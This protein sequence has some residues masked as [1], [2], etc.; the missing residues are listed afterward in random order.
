MKAMKYHP[1]KNRED[2]EAEEK[3]K[4]ISEAYQILSDP[5]KRSHYNTYGKSAPSDSVFVDPEEFFKQQF[6]G[7]K[8]VDI[9]GEISIAKDFKEAMNM[10]SKGE[11]GDGGASSGGAGKEAGSGKE[12]AS[13]K[14]GLGSGMSMEERIEIRNQRINKLSQS[15]VEKL[16]LFSDAFP[17][18][19]QIASSSPPIGASLDQMAQEALDSFRTVAVMETDTLKHENY[20][21]ELLHAI[22][23]TYTLKAYQHL[24]KYDVEEGPVLRRAWGLGSRFAGIMKEKAHIINETVGTFRTA[25]DLQTSFAKLQEMEKKKEEKKKKKDDGSSSDTG[26]KD[27]T[28]SDTDEDHLTAEE[29]ELRQKLEFEAASKG[30]EALWRGSKLEVEAVLR[31]VCDKVLS[32]EA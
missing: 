18:P 32:D 6:G 27:P 21:V 8:F 23:Y 3:F 20:G 30:L 29:R 4:L 10:M 26:R 2:P 14:E 15:L 11:E 17:L 31:D 7:D 1:D 22:G 25:L 13:V 12:G 28:E 16:S 19:E 9:I 5:Q 24:A